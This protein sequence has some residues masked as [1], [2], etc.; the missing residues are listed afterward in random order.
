MRA[1]ALCLPTMVAPLVFSVAACN[2]DPGF[3]ARFDAEAAKL[4]I[5]PQLIGM[6]TKF[7][8]RFALR[9]PV[10]TIAGL[11]ALAYSYGDRHPPKLKG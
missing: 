4:S 10:T 11:A 6:A 3:D 2:R 9:N 8:W 7:A 1:S 5:A